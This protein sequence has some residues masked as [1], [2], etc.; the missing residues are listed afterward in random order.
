MSIVGAK[1][2]AQKAQQQV[3]TQ[4]EQVSQF[5]QKTAPTQTT[6]RGTA[7]PL[8]AQVQRGQIK[9]VGEQ[10]QQE[11]T[12]AQQEVT[13]YQQDVQKFEKDYNDYLQSDSGKLQYVQETGIKPSGVIYGK[14]GKGYA[15]QVFANVYQTPYGEVVDR[16]PEQAARQM[17]AKVQARDLGFKN[18]AEMQ[19]GLARA[20]QMGNVF[21]SPSGRAIPL[22]QAGVESLQKEMA[23]V[24]PYTTKLSDFTTRYGVTLQDIE[25]AGRQTQPSVTVT[26]TQPTVLYGTQALKDYAAGN[27]PKTNVQA[28]TQ[29]GSRAFSSAFISPTQAVSSFNQQ[30]TALTKLGSQANLSP[31]KITSQYIKVVPQAAEQFG[32]YVSGKVSTGLNNIGWQGFETKNIPLPTGRGFLQ[33]ATGIRLPTLRE[34]VEKAN[35][36][37]TPRILPERLLTTSQVAGTAGFAAQVPFW[38]G[39]QQYLT[40]AGYIARGVTEFVKPKIQY[41]E[42]PEGITDDEWKTYTQQVD[43]YNKAQRL[44]AG[45]DVAFGSLPFAAR[46]L[47][48]VKEFVFNPRVMSAK[49][50][51]IE[52]QK[53]YGY[54][55]TKVDGFKPG[56]KTVVLPSRFNQFMGTKITVDSFKPGVL[57]FDIKPTSSIYSGV[58]FKDRVGYQ[59]ALQTLTKQGYSE[60]AAKEVLRFRRPTYQMAGTKA[61][62]FQDSLNI[63]RYQSAKGYLVSSG[64]KPKEASSMLK[65]ELG[66]AK[67]VTFFE[68]KGTVTGKAIDPFTGKVKA[69]KTYDVTAIT[70]QK[71]PDLFK[72]ELLLVTDD[73]SKQKVQ[74]E[75]KVFLSSIEKTRRVGGKLV[76][77]KEL[78]TGVSKGEFDVFTT[79]GKEGQVEKTVGFGRVRTNIKDVGTIG[80]RQPSKLVFNKNVGDI[81]IKAF[82][83]GEGKQF[84]K[85]AK[86]P[87]STTSLSNIITTSEKGTPA[88][89]DILG[90]KFFGETIPTKGVSISTTSLDRIKVKGYKNV[91]PYTREYTGLKVS[92]E[93]SKDTGKTFVPG[94]KVPTD[95][96]KLIVTEQPNPKGPT[97]TKVDIPRLDNVPEVKVI[98]KKLGGVDINLANKALEQPVGTFAEKKAIQSISPKVTT[99][100]QTTPF[101]V[102]GTGRLEQTILKSTPAARGVLRF[103]TGFAGPLTIKRPETKVQLS[104]EPKLQL[105]FIEP[106]LQQRFLEPRLEQKFIDMKLEQRFLEP[107]LEQKFMDL[108]L[109]QKFID[110]KLDQRL[111]QKLETK[112]SQR[113]L[114]KLT[115]PN[116]RV[117]TKI[118]RPKPREPKLKKTEF[119]FQ[120]FERVKKKRKL[121]NLSPTNEKFV[122]VTKRYGKEKVLG[123]GRTAREAEM[124]AKRSTLETLGATVKVRTTSGRQVQ[125]AEDRLFRQSKTDPLAIVQRQTARLASRGERREIKLARKGGFSLL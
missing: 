97:K 80:I 29:L 75:S 112:L 17:E 98:Q 55:P 89:K 50:G 5:Q 2:E 36:V 82:V 74:V 13:Q 11:V 116:V 45:L 39:P 101:Y 19:E 114:L 30:Q 110:Q 105:K 32:G 94:K 106:Q 34:S 67:D 117:T 107:K 4:Q 63:G 28:L 81:K 44:G 58:P 68:T 73:L 76:G 62:T 56:M 119:P 7:S 100:V 77:T 72:E 66:K 61:V 33:A 71:Q 104:L 96:F 120:T 102:G 26:T 23:S 60:Q 108:K 118:P 79:I 93:V 8:Q 125:L 53:I 6:L 40:G 46:A 25:M 57:T 84:F 64:V 10:A 103:E 54:K 83:E 16:S 78:A 31:I 124:I 27:I 20:G 95:E 109:Q 12:K 91:K 123:I 99:R 121:D 90:V 88:I 59:K 1:T 18:A 43:S 42:R 70:G 37:K 15:N 35:G 113:E 92:R 111:N 38:V 24:N 51:K 41:G 49:V 69:V 22:N 21:I 65:L 48:P 86:T 14:L 85:A 122:A 115:T 9:Q 3:Q 52:F 47:R 87:E